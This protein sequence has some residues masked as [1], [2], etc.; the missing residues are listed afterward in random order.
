MCFVCRLCWLC[1]VFSDVVLGLVVV[2]VDWGGAIPSSFPR[3]GRV[4]VLL[5]CELD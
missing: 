5:G 3:R 4:W 1:F 2:V